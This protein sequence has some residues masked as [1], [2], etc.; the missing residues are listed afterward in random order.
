M[1]LISPFFVNFTPNKKF[2]VIELSMK[3]L[4]WLVHVGE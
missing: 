4:I 2:S 3:S 1:F